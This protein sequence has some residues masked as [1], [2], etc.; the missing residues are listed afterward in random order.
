MTIEGIDLLDPYRFARG[1]HHAM[2]EVLR[3]ADPVYWHPDP[4]P[5]ATPAS[6]MS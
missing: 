4:V 2:F 1:E 3:A 6:G 5:V